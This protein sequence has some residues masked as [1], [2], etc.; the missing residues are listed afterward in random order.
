LTPPGLRAFAATLDS[1]GSRLAYLSS[2]AGFSTDAPARLN[3]LYLDDGTHRNTAATLRAL[4]PPQW[5]ADNRVAVITLE[6]LQADGSSRRLAFD[7]TLS[8]V[9]YDAPVT[10]D[11]ARQSPSPAAGPIVLPELAEVAGSDASEGL[12]PHYV[13]QAGRVFD[14]IGTGYQRHVDIHVESG[15]IAA[16]VARGRLPLPDTVIDATELTVLPGFID[17]HV[18]DSSLLGELAGRA[19]LAYGVT[20]VRSLGPH[21]A[22]QRALAAAWNRALVPGPRLIEAQRYVA[23]S[24][25]SDLILR[26]P[27]LIDDP[28]V[29][30]PGDAPAIDLFD[31]LLPP[32]RPADPKSLPRRFSPE[33][34]HYQDVF[35]LL[36]ASGATEITSLGAFAPSATEQLLAGDAA[37]RHVFEQLFQPSDRAVWRSAPPLIDGIAAR[38]QALTRLMRA[39]GRVAV[40]SES[41]HTPPG[42]GVHIEL[43]LFAAAGVPNDLVLRSATSSAALA[44]GL[45]AEIGTI[46]P[47]RRADLVIIEGDPLNDIADTLSIRAV[48]RDG[49]WIERAALISPLA[50][51]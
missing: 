23:A 2:V 22:A 29:T 4:A 19:W 40:G 18:H 27:A 24:A 43:S 30:P 41:P 6:T 5:L 49:R 11:N 7:A 10:S 36:A 51:D 31:A 8:V 42:L 26:P 37:A 38:Q 17:L 12:R 9:D 48:V 35:A 39:G 3:T 21:T 47:G 14:G 45:D 33:H 16:V 20:T 50:S 1:S 15:R 34:A 44:L 32:L 13:I 28:F 46:E 25:A